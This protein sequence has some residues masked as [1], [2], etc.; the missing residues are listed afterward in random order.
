MKP[1]L[2]A[3][4]LVLAAWAP[5]QAADDTESVAC[6][7]T[8]VWA[9]Y[10]E[11]WKLRTLASAEASLGETATWKVTLYPD[12]DYRFTACGAAGLGNLDLIVY[13][14]AGKP[15]AR[16]TTDD[17]QPDVTFRTPTLGAYYLVAHVRRVDDDAKPAELAI[18]ITHR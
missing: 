5:A 9:S 6:V 3:T 16:D 14:A 10:T 1:H 4:A 11:G 8:K 17:S 12:R 18:A 7:R 2:L 15:V 13:D